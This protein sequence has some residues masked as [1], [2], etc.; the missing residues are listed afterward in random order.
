[1]HF[2]LAISNFFINSQADHCKVLLSFY[3]VSSVQLKVVS[4]G[5]SEY[6]THLY[7]KYINKDSRN[8]LCIAQ[9]WNTPKCQNCFNYVRVPI[10]LNTNQMCNKRNK[11]TFSFFTH[12]LILQNLNFQGA[13]TPSFTL[14]SPFLSRFKDCF[15]HIFPF[16]RAL[17]WPFSWMLLDS[18]DRCHINNEYLLS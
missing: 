18:H 13:W 16:G 14:S 1:M 3:T 11:I 15:P 12:L 7:S 8:I 5:Q 2:P 6:K 17:I 4:Q 9:Q 10:V